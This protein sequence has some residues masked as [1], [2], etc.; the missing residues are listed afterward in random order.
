MLAIDI[1][2]IMRYLVGDDPTCIGA[3]GQSVDNPP[4]AFVRVQTTAPA[5]P[6]FGKADRA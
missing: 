2:L 6:F 4:G 3:A 1:S 5:T